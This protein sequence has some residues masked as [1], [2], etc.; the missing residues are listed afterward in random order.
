MNMVKEKY[1]RYPSQFNTKLI[2]INNGDYAAFKQFVEEAH[3]TMAE[4][5]HAILMEYNKANLGSS[6]PA[7]Q[8]PMS[9][10][11][12]LQAQTQELKTRLDR[13][14]TGVSKP[15]DKDIIPDDMD[16]VIDHCESGQCPAHAAWWANKKAELLEANT[17]AI[18][19]RVMENLPDSVVESEGLKRG[20]IPK[21]IIIPGK[22]LRGNP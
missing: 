18:V 3:V 11:F 21:K 7:E 9:T 6:T 22:F 8:I 12:N 17:P 19:Q 15:I 4:G 5:F 16:A 10:L 13:I 2:R 14:E 1:Q 20:F